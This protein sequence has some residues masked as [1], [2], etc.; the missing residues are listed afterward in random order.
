LTAPEERGYPTEMTTDRPAMP[1]DD[2]LFGPGS[3]T[4]RVHASPAM[5]IGGIR[6]LLIQ[7][8]HPLAMAGVAQHSNYQTRGLYR[9]RRTTQ[10]VLTVTYGDH[11]AAEAAGAQVRRVHAMIHGVDPVTGKSYSAEDPETLL[12]V[13]CV[14]VHSF[15]AAYRAYEGRLTPAEQDRYLAESARAAALVGIPEKSVPASVAEIRRY[16]TRI[17]PSLCVSQSALEAIRFLSAPPL[18]RKKMRVTVS[19]RIAAAAAVGLVPQHLRALAGLERPWVLD[20]LTFASLRAAWR[21][22]FAALDLPHSKDASIERLRAM[23]AAR[24]FVTAEHAAEA[25]VA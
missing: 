1:R 14:E 8:L 5:L 17:R 7:S 20:A 24:P 21:P 23:A 3:V 9:L 2:G 10:Y 25:R 18:A 22:L 4:W 6:A 11:A 13:H 12:W 15:L 19:L 16:F